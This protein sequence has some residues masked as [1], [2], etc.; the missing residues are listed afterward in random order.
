MESIVHDETA[1]WLRAE[2]E[3]GKRPDDLK[4]ELTDR[5]LNELLTDFD[6]STAEGVCK[7]WFLE[8]TIFR[9]QM[10]NEPFETNCPFGRLRVV[11]FEG[12]KNYTVDA[13]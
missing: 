8:D 10:S 1:T 13:E 2:F 5:I 12:L 3:R 7:H 6:R 4:S 9:A 11:W